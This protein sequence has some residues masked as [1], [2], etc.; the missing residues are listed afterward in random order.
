MLRRERDEGR[1]G[2]AVGRGHEAATFGGTN[3]AHTAHFPRVA[4][5]RVGELRS[6]K[7]YN[8]RRTDSGESADAATVGGLTLE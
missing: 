5:E 3:V 4:E 6:G 2:V 7:T 1:A 8:F